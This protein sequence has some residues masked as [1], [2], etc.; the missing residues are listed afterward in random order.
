MKDCDGCSQIHEWNKSWVFDTAKKCLWDKQKW[1]SSIEML[2]VIGVSK[3]ITNEA[4][5]SILQDKAIIRDIYNWIDFNVFYPRDTKIFKRELGIQN[6]LYILLGVASYWGDRKGIQEILLVAEEL[7][8]AKIILV[9]KISRTLRLPEN[10]ICVGT[11]KETDLLAKYY[12]MADVF[13]NPSVQE[14]FGKTTAEAI[15]CGTPVVAYETTACTELIRDGCG[16]LVPL[17][18][19]ESYLKTV[20]DILDEGKETYYL[21][22]LKFSHKNFDQDKNILEYIAFMQ[23]LLGEERKDMDYENSIGV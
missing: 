16:K 14:T 4:K 6:G 1:F 8:E 10:V 9:G 3:W 2:G 12:S 5:N 19:K 21:N 11:V 15:C 23:E 20:K 13:L 17:G 22:C 7:S 18:D